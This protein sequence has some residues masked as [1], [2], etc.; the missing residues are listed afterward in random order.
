[1]IRV[2][3]GHH[4]HPCLGDEG[5][6][7]DEAPFRTAA[8]VERVWAALLRGEVAYVS[9]DHA[10]W[11][12]ERKIYSGDI[13]AP[14]AGRTGRQSFAPLMLTLLEGRGLPVT[15][16]ARF[17]AE[18][19]ARFHGLSPKKGAIR[20][21]ADADLCV[22]ERGDF[23]FDAH[24]I[25]DREDARWSPYHGRALRA[26]VAATW[27]RGRLV[28]DGREVLA[29]PGAGRFVP[30]QHRETYLGEP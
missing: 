7:V 17:C 19:P 28:W 10:P 5:A 18:R 24:G 15:L 9:T 12:R 13:F 26:R 20:V 4:R 25:R 16:M 27:L 8:E 29:K 6:P 11:P 3:R 30:R 2:G 23:R 21:G 14:G 22:L 1:M